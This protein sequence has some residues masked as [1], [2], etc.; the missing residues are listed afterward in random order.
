MIWA[1]LLGAS[2][3][4][5]TRSHVAVTLLVD[6]LLMNLTNCRLSG[7]RRGGCL[8]L[9]MTVYG[10]RLA[11]GALTQDVAVHAFSENAY[12]M[13]VSSGFRFHRSAEYCAG[14]L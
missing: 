11:A 3:G 14:R 8:F 13:T 1:A 5:A 10:S 7:A 9:I 4:I 12:I 6:R 2:L